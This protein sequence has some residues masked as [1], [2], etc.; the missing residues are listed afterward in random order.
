MNNKGAA[1]HLLLNILHMVYEFVPEFVRHKALKNAQKRN[2]LYQNYTKPIE[3]SY[4]R[5]PQN[6]Y[7]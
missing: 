3:K 7:L 4:K 2:K 6:Q 1:W 5:R